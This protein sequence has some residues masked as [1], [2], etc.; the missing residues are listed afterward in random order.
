MLYYINKTVIILNATYVSIECVSLTVSVSHDVLV[1]FG[2][3]G[4]MVYR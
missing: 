1:I 4:S 2:E 3:N